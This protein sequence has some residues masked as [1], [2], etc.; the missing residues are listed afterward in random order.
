M[1][2]VNLIL[3][4]NYIGRKKEKFQWLEQNQIASSGLARMRTDS[5][6]RR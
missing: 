2:I 5:K 3:F 4:K 1:L 6:Q